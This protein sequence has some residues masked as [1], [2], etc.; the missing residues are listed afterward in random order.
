MTTVR[1]AK[2]RFGQRTQHPANVMIG[3]GDLAI[4]EIAWL[5]A[6]VGKAWVLQILFVGIE[7]LDPNEEWAR[8]DS[9]V[10]QKR[11]GGVGHSPRRMLKVDVA[12]GRNT[13]S[14]R[15]MTNRSNPSTH[16]SARIEQEV[17]SDRRGM[18]TRVV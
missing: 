12:T 2:R 10:A 8:S 9:G 15:A 6:K 7:K 4:V 5:V 1:A 14:P 18:V 11:D 13:P 16:P 17:R 3:K